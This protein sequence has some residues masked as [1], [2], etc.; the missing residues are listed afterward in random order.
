RLT[1]LQSLA[2]L[3][4]RL[5]FAPC[6]PKKIL[7]Q[8]CPLYFSPLP[9]RPLGAFAKRC[10]RID[11][12]AVKIVGEGTNFPVLGIEAGIHRIKG[13]EAGRGGC[14]FVT[15][16]SDIYVCRTLFQQIHII[17]RQA[18]GLGA[19][20]IYAII[21]VFVSILMNRHIFRNA[22]NFGTAENFHGFFDLLPF[23]SAR[24]YAL[25][26]GFCQQLLFQMLRIHI[27]TSFLSNN[28]NSILQPFYKIYRILHYFF[29]V[30]FI[31]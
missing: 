31:T 3:P 16:Q 18:A 1:A 29:P 22:A 14:A 9:K 30:N 6:Q 13:R 5:R 15:K 24:D 8:I 19:E 4:V 20:C 2:V 28:D 10:C 11:V 17:L 21:V 23:E 25:P 7:R 27:R 12:Y 26:S